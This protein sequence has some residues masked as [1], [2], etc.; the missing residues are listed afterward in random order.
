MKVL[1]LTGKLQGYRIPVLEK[2]IEIGNL[3]LTVAHSSSPIVKENS[4]IKE[5]IL[6]EKHF[7]KFSKHKNGFVSF[8]DQFD[9]IVA[10]FYIQKI[11]FMR[12][13]YRKDRKYKIVFWG[14]GVKT[15]QTH[16]FG[17]PSLTNT[18]RYKIAKKADAMIF[19]TDFARD[20]YIAQGIAPEK[21]FVMHNTVG[22][23][24]SIDE[25][26]DRNSILFVGSL[27]KRKKIDVLLDAYL[28]AYHRVGELPKLHIIGKGETYQSTASWIDENDM[29]KNVI[30]HGAIYD[31]AILESFFKQSIATISPGQAGL[32]VLQSMG[33]GAPF[34]TQYDAITGGERL[35]IKNGD[36]GILYKQ[37]SDLENIIVDIAENKERFIQLGIN[38]LNHYKESRTPKIMAQGFID[39]VNH[40]TKH[41]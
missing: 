8:C 33:Y 22:I 1:F 19:Y 16:K 20:R 31:E 38:A 2:I 10:M 24:N 40:V 30:L 39:A 36:N 28:K 25:N 27:L 21:I 18:M 6:D 9:V 14:I 35:N 13:L 23:A 7:W 5:V 4:K 15:S 29:T 26:L 11:S 32:S 3:D 17:A 41:H 12:L 37:D 34:I